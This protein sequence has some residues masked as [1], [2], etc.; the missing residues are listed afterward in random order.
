[1]GFPGGSNGKESAC[2]AGD[3]GSIPG[4]GRSP[5]K[6]NSN[7]LQYSCLENPHEQRSLVGYSPW[8]HKESDTTEQLTQMQLHFNKAVKTKNKAANIG[9]RG[10]NHEFG[11]KT[12]RK[13]NFLLSSFI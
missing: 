12:A 6:G 3:Q 1:M 9:S 10:K 13:L 2:N 4:E 11:G 5:G 8:H 7:P